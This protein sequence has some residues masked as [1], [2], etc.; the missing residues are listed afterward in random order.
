MCHFSPDIA[1]KKGFQQAVHDGTVLFKKLT[2]IKCA[3]TQKVID[4]LFKMEYY[5]D[6]EDV[7]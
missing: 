4:K 1:W 5:T 3:R 6:N 7:R 2:K